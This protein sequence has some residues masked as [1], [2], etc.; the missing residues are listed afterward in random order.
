MNELA[1][2]D[3]ENCLDFDI[4]KEFDKFYENYDAKQKEEIFRNYLI[5]LKPKYVYISYIYHCLLFD[6]FKNELSSSQLIVNSS[7]FEDNQFFSVLSKFQNQITFIKLNHKKYLDFHDMINL[8]YIKM[9]K[10]PNKFLIS[11]LINF[12]PP[13][14]VFVLLSIFTENFS[15][16]IDLNEGKYKLFIS[17]KDQ[18]KV[19]KDSAI[20]NINKPIINI[21]SV[22]INSIFVRCFRYQNYFLSTVKVPNSI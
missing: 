12:L 6:K 8:Q 18:N 19:D 22:F 20:L 5:M 17:I 1:K 13:G 7:K 15:N 11:D 21:E 9:W 14:R 10:K 4:Y 3:L 16:I 2:E